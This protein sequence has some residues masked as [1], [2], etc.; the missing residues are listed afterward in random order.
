[1]KKTFKTLL[2]TLLATFALSSCVDVPAPFNQPEKGGAAVGGSNTLASMDLLAGQGQWQTTDVSGMTGVWKY[3]SKYGMVASGF[4]SSKANQAE[5]WLT[6]PEIDLTNTTG[7]K[8]VVSE[9]I[10]KLEGGSV[11]DQCQVWAGET[12]AKDMV[13]LVADKRPAGSSWT[14]QDDTFDASAFDG[15]KIKLVLKYISTTSSAPSWEISKVAVVGEGSASVTGEASGS[16][17]ATAV[18]CAQ[19][20]E[21]TKALNDGATSTETY[22]ITGYITDVI[23][24]VSRNQQSFWIADTKDGGQQ[25]QAYWANLPEGVEAFTAGSKVS[26]TGQLTKYVKSSG[27][28]VAEMKNAN[29]VILEA[30]EGGNDEGG[31]DNPGDGKGTGVESDPY[32]VAAAIAYI[33]TLGADDKPEALVYTKGIICEVVKMGTSGSIQFRM[34]DNGQADNSLL[35]Y[36]CN[37]LG[38]EAFTDLSQLKVGDEV[39]V[40]GKVV[41]YKGDTPE[42]NSGAYLVALNGKTEGGNTDGGS[43]NPGGSIQHISVAEFLAKADT[44]NAYELT[45][46]VS[47]IKNTTYGNFDLVEDNAS[48]YIYGL[49]DFDG[50]AKN[51]ASLKIAEGDVITITGVY[52]DYNGTAEIKNAQIV[53]I[54]KGEGGS[55]EG[56]NDEGG[57]T[58]SD[59]TNGGFESWISDSEP[60]GWKSASTA[61]NATLKKS[62]DARSGSFAC[63]IVAPGTSNKRLASKEITLPAGSYKF[64]YYAK[65]TTASPSQTK[66]GYVPVTDGKVGSYK[67]SNAYVDLNSSSWT[68]VEYDFEL[69]E[70]TTLCLVVMNP[71]DS[72]Y[73]TSQDILIDDAT[74]TKK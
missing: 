63:A 34:S 41:N 40:C 45:G 72:G 12:G 25:F 29:V 68:L 58:A 2:C 52:V 62:T 60:E 54:E 35:V 36:Y 69:T 33:Q 26:I 18:T 57:A 9:A 4:K 61:S 7:S 71:K 24:N 37:N 20:V 6:S 59:L 32:N 11:A 43:D 66:G 73:S 3:D 21:L 55:D 42:Y 16:T 50:N 67:Y 19:A 1:M 39:T 51:F 31:N 38:N 65:S 5:A 30:G 44:E 13:L 48:I 22:T 46:V 70:E 56:G 53:K 27:E 28:M 47:N 10:N 49:L 23:G 64:S 14:F 15:K 74:L 17:E 8:I